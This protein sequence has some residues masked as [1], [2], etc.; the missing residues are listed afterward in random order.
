M[1][2][3]SIGVTTASCE[4][5][6]SLASLILLAHTSSYSFSAPSISA[7]F[8][9]LVSC[10]Q[11]SICLDEILAI[12]INY[13]AP[14]RSTTPCPELEVDL[15]IP[16][17]HLLPPLASNHPDP[18]IRHYTFRVLSLVLGLSPSPV[19]FQLLKDLLSDEDTPP[20]MRT[21][22][23]GLLKEAVMEG[24]SADAHNVFASP[25]LLSTFGP[26][27]LRPDSPDI[28]VTATC[29]DFLDGPEP[30]RLVECLGFFFVWLQ[31]DRNNRVSLL[32]LGLTP[33]LTSVTDGRARWYLTRK[34]AAFTA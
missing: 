17:I 31:R 15:I 24:L 14:L 20:Q 19:R 8:P 7:F 29:E 33:E 26:I 1:A 6:P 22:A 27:V 25:L 16:L 2:L 23:V 10:F 3:Q 4:N 9:V 32:T 21:A 34:Y 30:L 13:L 18:D 28:L 11:S 12:L 5:T